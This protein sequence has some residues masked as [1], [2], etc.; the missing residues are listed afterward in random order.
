MLETFPS[1][2]SRPYV[3]A[4]LNIDY[5]FQGRTVRQKKKMPQFYRG[6]RAGG[7]SACFGY[8]RNPSA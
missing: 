2:I 7:F 4:K 5:G 6:I 8:D 3:R 1:I